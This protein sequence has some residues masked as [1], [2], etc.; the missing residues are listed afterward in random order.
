MKS[1]NKAFTLIELLV[2]CA[3]IALLIALILPSLAK[4]RDRAKIVKCGANL[5]G[6]SAGFAIY[7]TQNSDLMP[8]GKGAYSV[9]A[10]P[11]T[12]NNPPQ[13]YLPLD[14]GEALYADGDFL[15]NSN[16]NGKIN[17]NGTWQY[18]TVG[19]GIFQCPSHSA[20]T[21]RDS[22]GNPSDSRLEQGY[23]FAW[24]AGS[25]F[26]FRVYFSTYP[27]NFLAPDP[28]VKTTWDGNNDPFMPVAA[29]YLTTDH[30]ILADGNFGM[31]HFGANN[32]PPNN[33]QYG[34]FERHKSNGK[35]GAN[36]LMAGGSVEFST[37]Y[38][39]LPSPRRFID[40]VSSANK[41]K[42]R[43]WVHGAGIP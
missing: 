42:E 40:Q 28:T 2:V 6:I 30:I 16:W 14:W 19:I 10:Y 31:C 1:R 39:S 37:L 15:Q 33:S 22:N 3:I 32:S 20:D 38:G 36:Y 29:K 23:G 9:A 4:A 24:C 5:H 25:Q 8:Q 18:F 26:L 11:S 43:I 12:N 35:M 34:V 41:N 21:Q 13:G 27:V 17:N 7:N